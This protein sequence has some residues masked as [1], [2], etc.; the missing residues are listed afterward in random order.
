MTLCGTCLNQMGKNKIQDIVPEMARNAGIKAKLT[1]QSLRQMTCQNLLSL[2][3]SPTVVIRL[4][5]HKNVNSLQSYIVADDKQQQTAR[6]GTT[7]L[8]G[9]RDPVLPSH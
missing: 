7:P 3:I 6:R 1:N 4:T 5:G 9:Y 2:G 8:D